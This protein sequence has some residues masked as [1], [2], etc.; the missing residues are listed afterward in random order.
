MHQPGV[1]AQLPLLQNLEQQS[2]FALHALPAVLHEVL[3]GW[4]DP[5]AHVPLQHE[6]FEVQAW[7]SETQAPPHVPLLQVSEQQSVGEAQAPPNEMH[8][9]TLD[10]Q[11]PV[12]ESHVAEQHWLP[13]WHALPVAPQPGPTLA[14]PP[15]GAVVDPPQ[16]MD[17][18]TIAHEHQRRRFIVDLLRSIFLLRRC[19][20]SAP[21]AKR[22][23]SMNRFPIDKSF[24]AWSVE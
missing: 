9:P 12:A 24:S 6:P 10:P 1:S 7:L 19:E 20:L 23:C 5:F 16:L 18:K 4:H 2:P 11:V 3:I 14:S 17:K 22:R 15:V 8:R 21:R 13:L